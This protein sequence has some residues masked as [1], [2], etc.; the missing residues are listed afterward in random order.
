MYQT[1]KAVDHGRSLL[2]APL[3]LMGDGLRLGTAGAVITPGPVVCDP[4]RPA[5]EKIGII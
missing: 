4:R 2:I 5:L 1:A 3:P